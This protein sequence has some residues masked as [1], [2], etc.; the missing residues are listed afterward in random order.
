MKLLLKLLFI[1]KLER[2]LEWVTDLEV[3]FV[4]LFTY[5]ENVRVSE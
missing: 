3:D 2:L 1:K 5:K 4:G